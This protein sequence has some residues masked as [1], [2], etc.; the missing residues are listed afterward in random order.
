MSLS[1]DFEEGF[2]LVGFQTL[3]LRQKPQVEIRHVVASRAARFLPL[4]TPG[5]GVITTQKV[6]VLL[7]ASNIMLVKSWLLAV[8]QVHKAGVIRIRR[9]NQRRPARVDR[10]T[11][12]RQSSPGQQLELTI[13]ASQRRFGEL[14]V[15]NDG[16]LSL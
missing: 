15:A 10:G 8:N 12:G 14:V 7:L 3:T 1:E 11:G 4:Y 2:R 13:L 5:R 16:D 9:Q 6:P